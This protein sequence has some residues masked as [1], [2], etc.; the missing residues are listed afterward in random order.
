MDN[1]NSILTYRIFPGIK[2]RKSPLSGIEVDRDLFSK[3]RKTIL[4]LSLSLCPIS[5]AK[6][7]VHRT[8]ATVGFTHA[9]WV[10]RQVKRDGT[11]IRD[12]G[13]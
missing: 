7:M 10:D 13:N 6:V 4:S 1:K 3:F 2:S 9:G 8:V 5:K 11:G 12:E